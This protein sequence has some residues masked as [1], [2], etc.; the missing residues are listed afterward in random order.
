MELLLIKSK[1][2]EQPQRAA[3]PD[4]ALYLCLPLS[5]SLLSSDQRPTTKNVNSLKLPKSKQKQKNTRSSR[6]R[7]RRRGWKKEAKK[8]CRNC[9]ARKWLK[10]YL[11]R[12]LK[13][14]AT[15]SSPCCLPPAYLSSPSTPSATAHL[16]HLPLALILG[17]AFCP[18]SLRLLPVLPSFYFPPIPV[19]VLLI[20]VVLY[21]PPPP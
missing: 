14:P 2:Q 1:V 10:F 13:L 5:L 17:T 15:Y 6:R 16:P 12:R 8:K 19:V 7:S 4:K 18:L 21:I 3:V 20:V 9:S 11:P